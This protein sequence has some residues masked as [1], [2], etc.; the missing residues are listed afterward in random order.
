[1][2]GPNG[3]QETERTLR[4]IYA[5]ECDE[6]AEALYLCAQAEGR[7]EALEDRFADFL[8]HRAVCRRCQQLYAD[9]VMLLQIEAEEGLAHA[10]LATPLPLP[11]Q[12]A[13]AEAGT[14]WRKILAQGREWLIEATQTGAQLVIDLALLLWGKDQPN[15]ALRQSEDES[16]ALGELTVA[17]AQAES[18][19]NLEVRLRLLPDVEDPTLA[20]LTAEISLPERWPDFSGVAVVLSLPNGESRRATTGATGIVRFPRL[21]QNAIHQMRFV[22]ELPPG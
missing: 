12:D 11:G 20:L 4:E 18:G 22:V 15:L 16:A 6:F 5:A 8:G 19:Y 7:G 10:P 3:A 9:V 1:M 21:P 13:L 14:G 2:A 17:P